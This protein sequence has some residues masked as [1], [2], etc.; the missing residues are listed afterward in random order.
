MIFWVVLIRVRRGKGLFY[1]L[2]VLFYTNNQMMKNQ[3]HEL[4][5]F[6][7]KILREVILFV[8]LFLPRF[9]LPFV[10]ICFSFSVFFYPLSLKCT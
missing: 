3:T 10:P 7:P 8:F 6:F 2:L 4:D 5:F 1:L 9:V